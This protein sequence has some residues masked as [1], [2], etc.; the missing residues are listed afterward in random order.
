MK[1]KDF[2][3]LAKAMAVVALISVMLG[4]FII[5]RRKNQV[6]EVTNLP[7]HNVELE[8]VPD[9]I[10]TARTETSFLYV[11]L[12]VTVQNH[13][14]V[15]IKVTESEGLDSVPAKPILDKIIQ[16]NKTAVQAIKGAELGSIVYISCVDSA[17]YKGILQNQK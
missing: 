17:L 16:E 4:G 3:A 15:N 12:A 8:Q 9:G 2:S 7:Y 13:K 1:K 14:I 10:Y 11:E 5:S 6:R